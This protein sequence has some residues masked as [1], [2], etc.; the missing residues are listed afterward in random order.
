MGRPIGGITA[1]LGIALFPDHAEDTDSL[2]RAA[3]E[4]LY[5]AKGADRDRLMVGALPRKAT[6]AQQGAA[7]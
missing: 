7:H 2:L 3:D 4:A 6:I 5:A 1:S